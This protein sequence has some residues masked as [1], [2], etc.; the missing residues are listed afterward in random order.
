MPRPFLVRMFLDDLPL[1]LLAM[2]LALTLFVLVRSDKDAATG[3]YVKVIYTLPEDR[4]L[5][6][7]PVSEVRVGL[8]GPWTRL[9]RF[10][11]RSIEPIR[12]DLS[13]VTGSELRFDDEMIK[14]P[15]GLR[16][17]SIVP[18]EVHLVFE[19]R[20]VLKVPVAPLLE[21]EPADGYRVARVTAEPATVRV[22]GAKSA[23][24]AVS[25]VPT[26][27]LRVS[28][29]RGSIKGDVALEAP[30]PHTRFLDAATVSVTAEIEPAMV[31]RTFAS[32]PV[33]V[34]GLSRLEGSVDPPA[35]RLILRGP[36]VL[37]SRI[38][39]DSLQ[40]AVDAS[41][42]DTRAPS[43]YLR[44]ITVSGLPPGV[45]AEVQPDKVLLTTRR[46]HE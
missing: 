18:S 17:T 41:L 3:A 14:L 6:S 29:A 21:G 39:G 35:A 13:K 46:K 26:R 40:L 10:D 25:R 27:P 2:V 20:V 22:D 7:D 30:P 42:V 8:R 37:V 1:K 4:V 24:E 34:N 5:V 11:E 9:Q 38:N 44:S 33:R 31:E 36:S 32:A 43:H 23:V 28:E 19:P 16:A 15:V 45:A 12:I